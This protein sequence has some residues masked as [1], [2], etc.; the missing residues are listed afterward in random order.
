MTR[1]PAFPLPDA[2]LEGDI[3]ILGKK[4]GGKTVTGKNIVERLLEL[5]HRVVILDPLGVWAGLRTSA[6]GKKPGYPVAIF[7]GEFGDLP[8]DAGGAAALAA[9]LATENLPAVIDLS[10]LSKADQNRFVGAFLAELRRVNKQALTLVLEEADVFAP[11]NPMGDDSKRVHAEIDWI[12]RR[13]RFKGFRL[14][15]ISQRPARLSKDVLTQANALIVHRLPAPQD[16]DAVKAWVDGNGD[17]DQAREVFRTLAGLEVGEAWVYAQDPAILERTR[18]PLMRTLDTSSTPKAGEARIEQK[19]LA[20]VD[21][22]GLRAALTAAVVDKHPGAKAKPQ[23]A[24][25]VAAIE[26]AADA[27]GYERGRRE[28]EHE[29]RGKAQFVAGDVAAAIEK[30]F[31]PITIGRDRQ[32]QPSQ[33]A[34]VRPT[35]QHFAA[36]AAPAARPAVAPSKAE[37]LD[38][39]R[40]ALASAEVLTRPQQELLSGLGWWLDLGHG[41]VTRPQLA[42]IIGWKSKGSHLRNRLSECR[43][44]GLIDYPTSGTIALTVEGRS[45]APKIAGG[46]DLHTRMRATF[47][48]PQRLMFDALLNQGGEMS[49]RALAAELRWEEGG[50]HLRNRLSELKSME[51]VRYPANGRVALQEWVLN[52]ASQ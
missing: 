22:A 13:G 40:T 41:S 19:S 2:L 6:D 43:G 9:V 3:A 29:A 52:G 37:R 8:L 50:S 4:G 1:R 23:L 32:V 12:A 39:A 47:S 25:D 46:G 33:P 21:V 48:Q 17:V 15:T 16:R 18:F 14:L 42:A 11:Q 10:E 27:R 24:A 35:V 28:A 20:Q 5:K 44:L 36:P 31:G 7:G 51:I 38:V 30:H 26:A 45:A 34:P 49:R